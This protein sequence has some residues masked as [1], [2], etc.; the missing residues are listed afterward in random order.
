MNILDYYKSFGYTIGDMSRGWPHGGRIIATSS[1]PYDHWRRQFITIEYPDK[2]KLQIDIYNFILQ[3]WDKHSDTYLSI[4]INKN[5]VLTSKELKLLCKTF[6]EFVEII[7]TIGEMPNCSTFA[8][9]RRH[10]IESWLPIWDFE[11]AMIK[12]TQLDPLVKTLTD[13]GVIMDDK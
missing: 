8:S 2:T 4:T 1:G 13:L 5:K 11:Q 7:K 10:D 6:R 9:I 3:G 12:N